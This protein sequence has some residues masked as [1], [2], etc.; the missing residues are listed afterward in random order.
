MSDD[1]EEAVAS[2]EDREGEKATEV[3]GDYLQGVSVVDGGTHIPCCVQLEHLH[4]KQCSFLWACGGEVQ[5]AEAAACHPGGA[6]WR[7]P[8]SRLS[9][10]PFCSVRARYLRGQLLAE[11]LQAHIK[12]RTDPKQHRFLK[13]RRI[14]AGV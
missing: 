11:G 5:C 2:D 3:A 14:D 10:T 7:Q 13:N 12:R 8:K 6:Q 1:E 4:S 9:N